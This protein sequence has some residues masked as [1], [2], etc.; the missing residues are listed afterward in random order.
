MVYDAVLSKGPQVVQLPLLHVLVRRKT[1]DTIGVVAKSLRFVEGKE[2]EES[3][4]IFLYFA[5]KLSEG[6]ASLL[7]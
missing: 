3:A 5:L 6:S 2:L 1:E 7:I 4:L